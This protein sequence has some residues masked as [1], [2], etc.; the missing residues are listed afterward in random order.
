MYSAV[1]NDSFGSLR[2][3]KNWSRV[4]NQAGFKPLDALHFACA[5][6]SGADYF[7]TCDDRLLKRARAAHSGPPKVVSPLERIAEIG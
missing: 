7:C 1:H 3:S 6:E 4:L 5:V 2:M